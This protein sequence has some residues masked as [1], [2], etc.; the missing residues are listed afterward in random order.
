VHRE[1]LHAREGGVDSR[2]S[3]PQCSEGLLG[4]G[5]VLLGDG[6]VEKDTGFNFGR[7]EREGTLVQLQCLRKATLVPPKGS[8]AIR[9]APR[10]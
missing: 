8:F 6:R 4:S 1:A 3:L 5:L 9:Q 10:R 2:F 7:C